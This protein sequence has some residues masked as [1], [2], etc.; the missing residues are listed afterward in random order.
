[1]VLNTWS[2]GAKRGFLMAPSWYIYN[3]LAF[4]VVLVLYRRYRERLLWFTGNAVL[5]ALLAQAAIALM[6]GGGGGRA[7]VLFNNPNQLGYFALLSINI[8][9]LLHRGGYVTTLS[10]AVGGVAASYLALISASKAALAG[11]ALIAL[12]GSLVRLRTL[13]MVAIVFGLT[14][15]LVEPMRDAVDQ[16]IARFENDQSASLAEER[17]Y[18][19]IADYPQYWLL[20]SGEGAYNRFR[21]DTSLGAHE[22]HSSMGTLFFCYGA[23]GSLIFATFVFGVMRGSG[24]RAW[25]LILP[26]VAYGMAHQGLRT[27]LFWVLLAMVVALRE[28]AVFRRGRR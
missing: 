22:I 13:V 15:T 5:A 8:L 14:F 21:D 24:F 1:V 11:I 28:D 27:T 12:V 17:G 20:G 3:A 23:V 25:L 10:L 4:L 16:T 26:S 7:T 19:R 2:L 18:D 6:F 9:F